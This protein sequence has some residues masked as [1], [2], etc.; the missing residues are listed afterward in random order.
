MVE[1]DDPSLLYIQEGKKLDSHIQTARCCV[2]DPHKADVQLALFNIPD[3]VQSPLVCLLALFAA[4]VLLKAL[5]AQPRWR[6]RSVSRKAK[7]RA[8]IVGAVKFEPFVLLS[9]S[10]NLCWERYMGIIPF[11][12]AVESLAAVRTGTTRRA[13]CRLLLATV[14]TSILRVLIVASSRTLQKRAKDQS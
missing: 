9:S 13:I 11:A 10:I 6:A 8:G 1:Q 12:T 4:I 2:L 7:A 14:T 5:S 3:S